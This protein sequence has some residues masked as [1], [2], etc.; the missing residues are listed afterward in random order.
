[1]ALV[2]DG[3][4]LKVTLGTMTPNFKEF[5]VRIDGGEWRPAETTFSWSPHSI[6]ALAG[7]EATEPATNATPRGRTRVRNM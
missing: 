6:C 5:R 4:A 1:V 3:D 7:A 2:P